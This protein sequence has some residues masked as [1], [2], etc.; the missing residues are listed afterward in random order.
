[1]PRIS[2]VRSA[3][4]RHRLFICL[5]AC[6]LALRKALDLVH[7]A[8]ALVPEH[9]RGHGDGASGF[10]RAGLE[11]DADLGAREVSPA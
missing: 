1:M 4:K 2:G 7:A 8:E 3:K 11:L 5:L 9:V 10:G 6:L